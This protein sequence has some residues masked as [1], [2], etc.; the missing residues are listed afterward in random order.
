MGKVMS[1]YVMTGPERGLFSWPCF[2]GYRTEPLKRGL[3]TGP[4]PHPIGFWLL[5][6]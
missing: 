4:G 1:R 6:K 3:Q 2:Q 5:M